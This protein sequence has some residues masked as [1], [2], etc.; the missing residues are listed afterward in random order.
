MTRVLSLTFAMFVVAAAALGGS[1]VVPPDAQLV[2]AAD[3][4]AVVRVQSSY[5]YFTSDG[6]IATDFVVAIEERLR[7]DVPEGSA[8][9]TQKGGLVG[10][11]AMWVSTSVD[12]FPGERT[13]L[14]LDRRSDRKWSIH[15]GALGKFNFV[16]SMD[17]RELLIRGAKEEEIF[18]W[19]FAGRRHVE[20]ARDAAAFLSYVRGIDSAPRPPQDYFVEDLDPDALLEVIANAT[21]NDYMLQFSFG[22]VSR[23]ARWPTGAFTIDREGTQSGVANVDASID[24]SRNAWN[25]HSASDINIRRGTVVSG[26]PYESSDNENTL[27]LDQPDSGELSGSVVGQARIWASSSLTQS[28]SGESFYTTTETDVIIEAGL[29]GSI[30]EEVLAHELG[31]SLG[32][33]HS[34]ETSALM[35]A[36]VSGNTINGANLGSWD[37]EGASLVYGEGLGCDPAAIATHPQSQT[38]TEGQSA[39]LSVG[40]SGTSPLSYQ[41]FLDGSPIS[42]ATGSSYSTPTSLPPG[43]YSYTVRVTNSCNTAGATS[44][45]ATVTVNCAVPSITSQPQSKTISSGESTLLSVS[46]SGATAYQWYRGSRNDESN[47]IAGATGSSL[48]TG[49]LTQTTSYWVKVSNACGS[50]SSQTATLTVCTAPAITQQPQSATVVAGQSATLAVSATGTDLTYQWFRGPSGSTSSPVSGANGPVFNTGPLTTSTSF[51]VRVRN[52]CGSINS[53]AATVTVQTAC[54]APQ[55]TMQPQPVSISPGESATL[56][57]SATGTS[58]Q[59][60][61]YRGVPDNQTQPVDGATGP[62]FQTGPL[63]LTTQFWVRVF[64]SCGS[65]HSVA[66]VVTV[67]CEVVITQQPQSVTVPRGANAHFTVEATGP[68][69]LSYQWYV[70][71]RGDTSH[72]ISGATEPFLG[73]GAIH[74]VVQFWVRVSSPCGASVDSVTVTAGPEGGLRRRLVRRAP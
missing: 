25:G 30:F 61:W 54:E 18:G 74:S 59:Y 64:N 34:P 65:V 15:A 7:G 52:A 28:A 9:V 47:P 31:H 2:L 1:Y 67:A 55:I 42:G 13:L 20:P 24:A 53:Q 38:I 57:V 27:F 62:T 23:G 35:Y 58:L 37:R 17:G 4:A 73:T 5:G 8:I 56:A 19:D 41:W 36:S 6:Q 12:L 11:R 44:N 16:R 29:T 66:A 10:D 63:Q 22:G 32:F 43:T 49:S 71:P 69:P 3:A 72:P 45:P 60:Q 26:R 68:Q 70:G 33:K 50:T 21:G 51:W 14:L 48:N 40:A 39:S 46:A